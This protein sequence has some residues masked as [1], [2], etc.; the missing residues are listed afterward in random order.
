MPVGWREIEGALQRDFRFRD[1]AEAL[2][3]L[4]RIGAAAEQ[5]NHHPDVE[6]HWNRLTL[7]WWTHA[8]DAITDRDL[9]MAQKTNELFELHS[10]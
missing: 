9:A 10:S 2:R 7:R 3:F 6:L 1:F 4:N 8:Q 5:A